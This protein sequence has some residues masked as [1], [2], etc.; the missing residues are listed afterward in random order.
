MI[1]EFNIFQRLGHLSTFNYL[2]YNRL[3]YRHFSFFSKTVLQKF[4]ML[5]LQATEIKINSG[6]Q[7]PGITIF[8][9]NLVDLSITI[10]TDLQIS[11]TAILDS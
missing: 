4:L 8:V 2:A 1:G 6:K 11:T 5:N 3:Y 9:L 10:F 7:I